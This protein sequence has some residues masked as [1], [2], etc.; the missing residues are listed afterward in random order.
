MYLNLKVMFYKIINFTFIMLFSIHNI[1]CNNVHKKEK[2]YKLLNSN[3]A[4]DIIKGCS[5]LKDSNDTVFVPLLLDNLDD[6]RISHNYK[7]YGIS[8]YESKIKALKR[9]SKLSPPNKIT[10]KMDASNIKFYKDCNINKNK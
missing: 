2:I 7:F 9:I 10:Y 5:Y 4:T 6:Q 8:V 1:S 3:D